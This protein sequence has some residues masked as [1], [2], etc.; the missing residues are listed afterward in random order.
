M[1]V[2]ES[3]VITA[4]ANIYALIVLFGIGKGLGALLWAA[5][6]ILFLAINIMPT[7]KKQPSKR[8][9]ALKAASRVLKIFL[10]STLLSAA[11]LIYF[12]AGSAFE[13]KDIVINS[14]VVFVS[15][16]IVFWNGIIR[17]YLRSAQLGVKWRVIGLI[18]G[19][20][21]IVN[22]IVLFKMISIADS[23]CKVESEKL[24]LDSVRAENVICRTKY[25]ILLVH[26]VFFR[27]FRFF[28]YWGRVP[29]VLKRNGAQLYYGSQ[30]SAA[31]VAECGREIAE[32]I[33]QIVSETG[34]EKLNIIAHS[35]GGLDSRYAVSC[36]GADK[37]VA[38]LTTINSPHRGCKFADFLLDKASEKL[39][40]S[41]AAKYNAALAK[42][43]DK[44]PDFISAVKDLT[45]ARCE[46]IN[47]SCPDS[48][49]VYYQSVGSKV[50][51]SVGGRFPLNLSYHLVKYFDNKDNDGL[52]TVDSMKWGEDFIMLTPKGERGISHGDI[53]DLNRENFKGFD[54]REFYVG[55]VKGL[56]DKGF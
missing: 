41:V 39:C 27:D 42:L 1:L 45:A 55:L 31:S 11:A 2:L 24:I 6:V 56:K 53:I 28:N 47:K 5:A 32:R 21:P 8:L 20:I 46:E 48:P 10:V 33:E 43:G 18:C 23:E 14:V 52:V 29:E 15:E 16:L 30:R 25:P 51:R 34:C 12:I 17:L 22:L 40:S 38:S 4:A 36:L 19:M 9:T 44:D 37:Y 49:N 3:L 7:I 50:K 35:K 13:T 54:V 26:G